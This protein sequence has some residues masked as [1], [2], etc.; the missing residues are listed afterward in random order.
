MQRRLEPNAVVREIEFAIRTNK[1]GPR[2]ATPF[3]LGVFR[4]DC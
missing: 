1:R 4:E 2:K 3:A